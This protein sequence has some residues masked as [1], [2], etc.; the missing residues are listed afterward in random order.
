M[1]RST[2]RG[3]RW[4]IAGA[5]AAAVAV[6]LTALVLLRVN[7]VPNTAR[8]VLPA[9]THWVGDSIPVAKHHIW[10]LGATIVC[11]DKPGTVTV[12]DVQSYGGNV[13]VTGYALRPNPVLTG[14]TMLG[15]DSGT[16]T[17]HHLQPGP[18]PVTAVCDPTTGAGDELI[19]ELRNDTQTTIKAQG[20]TVTYTADGRTDQ[21]QVPHGI[22]LCVVKSS[23]PSCAFLPH[24]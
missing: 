16:L 9:G 8:L 19:V 18:A 17:D 24:P 20:L 22:V 12:T 2:R 11:L 7:R 1:P 5:A 21:L 4:V 23:D 3:G 10:L 14:G 6:T 13:D 15:G